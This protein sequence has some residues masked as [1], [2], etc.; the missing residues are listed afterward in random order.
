MRRLIILI[1]LLLITS[2]SNIKPEPT[3]SW[4]RADHAEIDGIVEIATGW[5][6]SH[7]CTG[8][9]IRNDMV[10]TAAHCAVFP[11]EDLYIIYGCNDIDNSSC[12]RVP[13][14]NVFVHPKWDL[15]FLSTNDLAIMV[16]VEPIPLKLAQISPRKTLPEGLSVKAVGFGRRNG[17]SGVLYAGRG[18]IT[19]D[20][21]YELIAHMNGSL[22]PNPGDSGGP[23]LVMDNGRFKIVG[24]LSRSR[25][26]NTSKKEVFVH[27]GH[28]IY[29]KPIMY[30]D[31]INE[32]SP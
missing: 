8:S 15:D 22:D 18:R 10:L 7:L 13:V 25:W 30:I 32:V 9:L 4:N 29:T 6:G 16:P 24:V 28:A 12:Q 20:Y 23:L 21:R 26:S 31:W 2:C 19:T 17:D 5:G 3:T 27:S 1:L 14:Q 11:A